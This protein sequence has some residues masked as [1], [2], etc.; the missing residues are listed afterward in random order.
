MRPLNGVI[1]LLIVDRDVR[2]M[3]AGR[4]PSWP[5]SAESVVTPI[6]ALPEASWVPFVGI[7]VV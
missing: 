3:S 6:I 4:P 7:G 2:S 5:A 1:K